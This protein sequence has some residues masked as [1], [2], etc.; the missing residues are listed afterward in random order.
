MN[1]TVQR[2]YSFLY[3]P[4]MYTSYWV[5]YPL[6]SA[7]LGSGY[8]ASW[9]KD[10]DVASS[11]QTDC[12]GGY[13][14]SLSTTN[15]SS[16]SYGRG[17]QIPNADRN[18]VDAMNSQ[19]FYSTNCTPQIQNGFN[20]SIWSNL[21]G[22]VRSAIPSGDTLYVVTG[23]A[24][25]VVGGSEAITYITNSNDNKSIPV[26]NYYWKVILK[27][28]RSGTSVTSAKAIGFWLPHQD[29]GSS[30][31]SGSPTYADFAVSVDTIEQYTGFNFFPNLPGN[32]SSG[33]EAT[34]EANSSW[35][36]F[37]SF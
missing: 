17:H 26:P 27:V 6:C 28:K 18:G 22:A 14:V 29:L 13:G 30:K 8:S 12:S 31:I 15:Y 37:Q 20:G 32:D 9:Q 10:P 34:A 2:N 7:H 23:A 21:E 24:F 4:S 35:T 25:R 16:N 36:D 33:I 5:A 3:D 11:K 19:T 1:G